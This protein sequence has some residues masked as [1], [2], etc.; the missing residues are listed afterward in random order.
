[1]EGSKEEEEEVKYRI[2]VTYLHHVSSFKRTSFIQM[3]ITVYTRLKSVELF[4]TLWIIFS[5]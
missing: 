4:C 5:S 2:S 1:M 3:W